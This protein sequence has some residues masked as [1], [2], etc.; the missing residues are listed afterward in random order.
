MVRRQ[1]LFFR[2]IVDK[3][4]E[5]KKRERNNSGRKRAKAR[6]RAN[7]KSSARRELKDIL[8]KRFVVDDV[9]VDN[10]VVQEQQQQGTAMP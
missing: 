5:E 1:Y 8:T 6:T 4:R 10:E 3:E 7:Q 2:W 9:Q